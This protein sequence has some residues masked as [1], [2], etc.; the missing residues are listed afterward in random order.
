MSL[1]ALLLSLDRQDLPSGAACLQGEH[2]SVL[3]AAWGSRVPASRYGLSGSL[4][5]AVARANPAESERELD[6]CQPTIEDAS[7]SLPS[8]LHETGGRCSTAAPIDAEGRLWGVMVAAWIQPEPLPVGLESRLAESTESVATAI[9]NADSRAELAVSRARIV[10]AGDETR[11]RIKRGSPRRD[12]AAARVARARAAPVKLPA[13]AHRAARRGG[14][15]RGRVG[16]AIDD[17]RRTLTTTKH[18]RAS[19]AR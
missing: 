8:E 18:A 3:Q 10:G 5:Q 12:A 14:P 1:G 6:I 13:G 4:P 17:L 7:E 2:A 15:S 11:R 16:G 19:R 9:A